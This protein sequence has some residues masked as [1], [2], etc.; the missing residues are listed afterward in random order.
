MNNK[1]TNLEEYCKINVNI[2]CVFLFL[3]N[4]KQNTLIDF[5]NQYPK[6]P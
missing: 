6:Y 5:P 4:L 3:L 2:E 1:N